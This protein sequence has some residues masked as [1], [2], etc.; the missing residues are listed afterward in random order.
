[1]SME[2]GETLLFGVV[3]AVWVGLL[4]WYCFF[5]EGN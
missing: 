3:L 1:M 5:T 2:Q 4:V